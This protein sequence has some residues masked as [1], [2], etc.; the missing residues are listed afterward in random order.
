MVFINDKLGNGFVINV[1]DSSKNQEH[2]FSGAKKHLE[3]HAKS[4]TGS[5]S[6]T[7]AGATGNG[8]VHW[9]AS[10]F[11]LTITGSLTASIA[12]ASLF[13]GNGVLYGDQSSVDQI[14]NSG[15][16]TLEKKQA[17][18]LSVEVSSAIGTLDPEIHLS[19]SAGVIPNIQ[20]GLPTSLSD[21]W[22]R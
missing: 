20:N 11:A 16:S 12:S 3:M 18:S 19:Y 1:A 22:T 5:V 8:L 13:D 4:L 14:T 6:G 9:D 7:H 21:G 10:N 17:F 2:Y 15:F